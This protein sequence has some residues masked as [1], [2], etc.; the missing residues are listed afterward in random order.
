MMEVHTESNN[1]A[2][3]F[4]YMCFLCYVAKVLCA[5]KTEICCFYAEKNHA[6]VQVL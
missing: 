6:T 3:T 1:Q 2:T 5:S 4:L